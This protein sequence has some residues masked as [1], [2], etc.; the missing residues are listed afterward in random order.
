HQPPPLDFHAQGVVFTRFRSLR[1]RVFALPPTDRGRRFVA[2]EWNKLMDKARNPKPEI[3]PP[4]PEE[5]QFS[6]SSRSSGSSDSS[7]P[8]PR[9]P[10]SSDF[11]FRASF[12]FR[13][14]AFG[15]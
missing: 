2:T 7:E 13:V 10:T 9:R 15:F 14:S 4:K 11:G 8:A 1:F 6:G 3:R 5:R 12:G